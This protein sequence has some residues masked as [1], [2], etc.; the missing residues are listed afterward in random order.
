[1]A[2]P[3]PFDPAEVRRIAASY[4]PEAAATPRWERDQHFTPLQHR[5]WTLRFRPRDLSE[6]IDG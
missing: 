2:D 4:P 6:A 1:M 3:R 5:A